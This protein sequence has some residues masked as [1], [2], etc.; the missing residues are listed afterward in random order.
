MIP[1][2][3]NLTLFPCPLCGAVIESRKP[4]R[5]AFECSADGCAWVVAGCELRLLARDENALRRLIRSGGMTVKVGKVVH[6]HFPP[7]IP[8]DSEEKPSDLLGAAL[9][10]HSIHTGLMELC[11]P[12]HERMCLSLLRWKVA[13][14]NRSKIPFDLAVLNLIMCSLTEWMGKH[15]DVDGES[16]PGS[17]PSLNSSGG[18]K[19]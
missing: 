17:D 18:V 7:W 12:G 11:E 15:E 8:E 14:W 1:R 4:E 13:H 5:D 6:P 9:D 10:L 16:L 3:P 2:T 19:G